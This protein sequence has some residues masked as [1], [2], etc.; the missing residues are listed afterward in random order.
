MFDSAVFHFLNIEFIFD[1]VEPKITA[2]S[3]A[4]Y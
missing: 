1:I 3:S 2:S 4:A